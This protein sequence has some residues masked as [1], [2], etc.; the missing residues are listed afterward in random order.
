MEKEQGFG[1]I[2]V[3][4]KRD[5]EY[6]MSSVLPVAVPGVTYRYWNDNQWWGNQG[7]FPHCV[8]YAWMHWLEDGPVTH[9]EPQEPLFNPVAI[10]NEAQ[11]IDEWPGENYNGTSVR[12]GA[13][14]LM[15]KG[16]VSAY[17]WAASVD[18]VV[19]AVLTTGPVVVG[20]RWY[21]GMSRPDNKYVMHVTGSVL[22]GHAYMLSGVNVTKRLF[23]IKNS[24]GRNWGRNG[25]AYLGFDDLA[26]L[27]GTRGEAC[28]ATEINS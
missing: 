24:W 17:H 9:K 5:Q 26:T 8:A 22:G 16:I 4:D 21:A 25:R 27:I 23:R 6:L 10:Y 20:S 11:K 28:L 1:R 12:A 3:E 7:R 18:D 19:N 2:Y 13:K 15:S 14:V